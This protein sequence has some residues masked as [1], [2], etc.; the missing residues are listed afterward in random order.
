MPTGVATPR[1]SSAL[2]AVGGAPP[3]VT[4]RFAGIDELTTADRAAWSGLAA[5]ALE[6]NPFFEP[7]FLIPAARLHP[8]AQL[9]FVEAEGRVIGAM[10]VR[11]TRRWR[12][13]PAPALWA[14]RHTDAYLGTPLVCCE[15]AEEAI[16]GLVD[17]AIADRRTGLL[18]L[19]WCGTGG[20]FE[21][22]LRADLAKRGIEPIAYETVDRAALRRR[23]DGDYLKGT[24][25]NGR[26]RELRRL[27]RQLTEL[28]EGDV[29][30]HDRSGDP[31]AVEGFLQAEA[32]G[33]KGRAGT[34]FASS[35]AYTDFFRRICENLAAAGRLQLLVLSAGGVDVAWKVNIVS[36][37]AVFCFKIAHDEEFRRFSPGVQLELENVEIFH[38]GTAAW[39]DS[40]ADPDNEMIN[41]LWPDR[42]EVA[43]LLVPTGGALGAASKQSARAVIALRK[44][45]RRT[46]EQAA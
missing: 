37:G 24:V 28:L 32:R 44:R 33:W 43:T 15:A 17:A 16:G 7:E 5:R 41:R 23:P 20:R 1:L 27:R 18:V 10:P 8:G 38:R 45:I 22:L 42:R 36:G 25:S 3:V 40:C 9:L 34:N 35:E 19:E 6:P 21:E 31:T 14:W 39:S 13:L 4:A 30:V 46:D 12:K 26:G 29:E 2:A 11:R